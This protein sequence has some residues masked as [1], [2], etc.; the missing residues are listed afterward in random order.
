MVA[1]DGNVNVYGIRIINLLSQNLS[2]L[3]KEAHE[4]HEVTR[5]GMQTEH[6]PRVSIERCHYNKL[7]GDL[8][9]D[10]SL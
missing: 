7:L 9:M 8:N 6:P 1:L 2:E 4:R 3:A 5:A 10:F